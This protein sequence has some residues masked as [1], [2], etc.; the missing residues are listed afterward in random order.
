MLRLD[1][2]YGVILVDDDVISGLVSIVANSC[3]GISGMA[4]KNVTEE[5][6]DM[7][8]VNNG[9]KGI[10]VRCANNS[11]DID[12]HIMVIYGINIP[13]ITDSIIHKISYSVEQATGFPV[14]SVNVF[15]DAVSTK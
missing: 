11:I 5:I 9:E 8:K 14:N 13:A 6:R 10:S 3:F 2:E 1:N 15:I 4:A 7:F 12:I